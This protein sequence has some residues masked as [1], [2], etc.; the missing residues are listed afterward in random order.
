M[1]TLTRYSD[2]KDLKKSDVSKH[3]P[4]TDK[5]RQISELENFLSL[6]SK[7]KV[8]KQKKTKTSG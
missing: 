2:F 3:A 7:E 1:P 4:D 8:R 5:A 6:L